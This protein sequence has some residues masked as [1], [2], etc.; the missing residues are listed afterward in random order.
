MYCEHSSKVGR[1]CI[2]NMVIKEERMYSKHVVEGEG[3][4]S[5]HSHVACLRR[6][7]DCWRC[8]GTDQGYHCVSVR[9]CVRIQGMWVIISR[10]PENDTSRLDTMGLAWQVAICSY[11]FGTKLDVAFVGGR[12][13]CHG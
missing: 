11:K 13:K 9:V 3:I 4:Y 7:P 12:I 8:M 5:E 10:I 6:G 1:A 2:L